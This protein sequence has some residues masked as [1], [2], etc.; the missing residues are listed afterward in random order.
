MN[1]NNFFT[2][3]NKEL[4]VTR[5]QLLDILSQERMS[6][7][8]QLLGLDSVLRA[9]LVSN[10]TNEQDNHEEV[11]QQIKGLRE[12]I[13]KVKDVILTKTKLN[14]LSETFKSGFSNTPDSFVAL[15][16]DL[17]KQLLPQTEKKED[18]K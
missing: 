16:D 5:G 10:F 8:L 15:L 17:E 2:Q 13:L 7:Y 14:E 12:E 9:I 6:T 3:E 11:I 18:E 1:E 4:P